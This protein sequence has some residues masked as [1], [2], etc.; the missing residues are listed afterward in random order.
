MH[1]PKKML[2]LRSKE[3]KRKEDQMVVRALLYKVLIIIMT[4]IGL[5]LK[6]MELK[7]NMNEQLIFFKRAI[8]N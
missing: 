6:K 1:L 2:K 5:I 4:G 7:V 8:E 3:Y